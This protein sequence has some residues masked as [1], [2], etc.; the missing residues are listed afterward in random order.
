MTSSGERTSS[1]RWGWSLTAASARACSPRYR[2][3][4]LGCAPGLLR[5]GLEQGALPVVAL[6]HETVRD[7]Q[8]EVT[9]DFGDRQICLRDR[10][11]TPHP[12]GNVIGAQGSFRDD[13]QDLL[14]PAI[15]P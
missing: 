4:F 2:R 3:F 12:D 10:N 5:S 8:V 14:R 7:Q 1:D 9:E 11:I 13:A 6:G 15:V